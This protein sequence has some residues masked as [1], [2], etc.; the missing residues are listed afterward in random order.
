MHPLLLVIAFVILSRALWIRL[1]EERMSTATVDSSQLLARFLADL[2]SR[3]QDVRAKAARN[4]RTFVEGEARAMSSDQFR[5][6]MND[7][8]RRIFDLVNS[9]DENEKLGAIM[10]IGMTAVPLGSG[11]SIRCLFR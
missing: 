1:G 7:L 3:H 4:L 10:V 2:R 11:C 6:Y 8:N 9:S 5:E